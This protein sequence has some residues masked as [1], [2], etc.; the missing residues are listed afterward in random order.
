MKPLW[1]WIGGGLLLALFVLPDVLGIGVGQLLVF[2]LVLA[3]PAM[4]F[5]MGHGRHG[6]GAHGDHHGNG[7]TSAPRLPAEPTAMRP[8]DDLESTEGGRRG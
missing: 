6:G 3:C 1:L 2:L 8:P 4:H 5:F 7:A